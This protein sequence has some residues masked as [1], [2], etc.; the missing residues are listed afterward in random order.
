M[1]AAK[2]TPGPWTVNAYCSQV[3][4]IDSDGMPIPVCQMLWPTHLRIKDMIRRNEYAIAK[5][6][7]KP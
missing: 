7:G 2:H 5:A 4:A 1:S 3:D 6:E